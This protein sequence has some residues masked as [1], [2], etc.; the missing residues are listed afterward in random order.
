MT[1]AYTSLLG[2]AL[3]VTG[4]LSGT[5]GDTV[6]NS[7]TSLLDSAI[8]GTTTLNIDADITLTTTTGAANTSREAILLWTASGSATRTVTV[9]AQSKIYTVINASSGTQSIKIVGVGPTTGLT[10]PKGASAVIAWNGSDF[11]E[12]GSSTAGNLTVNGN[13][14]VTGTA[15]A[16]K[17]IP[18]GAS[19]TGN[20]MYLP[21]TNSVGIS[22]AGTNAVYIDA[23]Q[24]VGIGTSSPSEKLQVVGK[25]LSTGDGRI[26][27]KKAGSDTVGAGPFFSLQNA[28][29]TREWFNQLGASN[30]LD[31]W[32]YNGSSYTKQV[33]L[34][35]SGNVGIGM[36]PSGDSLLEIYGPSSATIYKNVNTGTGTSDGFYVGMAKS[37]GTDGYVYNRESG[38][39]IFGTANTERMRIHAAGGLS[40]GTTAAAPV[41]GIA[42]TPS[43]GVASLDSSNSTVT[44]AV[45]GTQTFPSASGMLLVTSRTTGVTYLYTCGAGTTT[46]VSSGGTSIGTF[47]FN[48]TSYVF[49][50]TTLVSQTYNFM[51]LRTREAA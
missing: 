27:V 42:V 13:L 37:S 26:G 15:T 44:L 1:T 4:E 16:A 30:S 21:A 48:G 24:N 36:T 41:G 19:V 38:N 18:T 33:T 46:Q 50:N 17:L 47:T 32:F 20:G 22:T 35:S 12:I 10:I 2:L 28:D 45:S 11:I 7:I 8:A 23:S 29:A 14:T 9:P 6:N 39:L 51:F 43:A 31:W 5:W 40:I 34:D 49:T 25:I 3:P